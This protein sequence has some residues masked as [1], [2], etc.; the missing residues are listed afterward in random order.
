MPLV[1]NDLVVDPID[2]L[3]DKRPLKMERAR[4]RK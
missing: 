3:P 4:Q 2:E 1:G